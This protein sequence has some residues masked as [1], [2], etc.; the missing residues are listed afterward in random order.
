VPA[1]PFQLSEY[2]V[3]HRRVF[4]AGND[5][6]I[7]IAHADRHVGKASCSQTRKPPCRLSRHALIGTPARLLARKLANRHAVLAGATTGFY[8]NFEYTL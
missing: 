4:D 3:D 5:V 2:L 8:I 6:H 7:T 1:D